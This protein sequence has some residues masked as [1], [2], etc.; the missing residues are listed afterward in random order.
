MTQ[1]WQRHLH[2]RDKDLT[3]LQVH[4]GRAPVA[5]CGGTATVP[6]DRLHIVT[7]TRVTQDDRAFNTRQRMFRQK[8]QNADVLP[9][10][11]RGAV[12]VL[13]IATQF[14]KHGRQLP[15]AVDV[16]VVQGGRLAL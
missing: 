16:G 9:S 2:R 7:R 6:E 8:L 15:M 4:A 11:G 12:P 14:S 13:E 1:V 5:V 10:P 3:L